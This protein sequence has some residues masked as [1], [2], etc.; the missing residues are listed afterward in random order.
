MALPFVGF[1][2]ISNDSALTLAQ[3]LTKE[4]NRPT[5]HPKAMLLDNINLNML[6][7]L[8][9]HA[10]EFRASPIGRCQSLNSLSNEE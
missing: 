9:P 5:M 8:W 10:V 6:Q 1:F 3:A 7:L 4:A 2:K